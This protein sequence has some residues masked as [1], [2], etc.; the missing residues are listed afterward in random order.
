VN[1]LLKLGYDKDIILMTLG[2]S[3]SQFENIKKEIQEKQELAQRAKASQPKAKTK[4]QL[5]RER[6]YQ[7]YN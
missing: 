2:I 5:L 3:D 4:I 7:L 1:Q 6:Y